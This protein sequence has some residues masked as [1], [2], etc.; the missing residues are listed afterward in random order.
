MPKSMTTDAAG[1][2]DHDNPFGIKGIGEP[3]MGSTGVALLSTITDA[4]GGKYYF[5]RNPVIPDMIV[6][7]M[8]GQSQSHRP[9]QTNTR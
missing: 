6:N 5:N 3:V 4:M 1:K 9:L 8:A 2:E 7:A